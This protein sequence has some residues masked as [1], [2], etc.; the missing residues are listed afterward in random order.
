[1]V[2]QATAEIH[3][4]NSASAVEIVGPKADVDEDKA[5]AGVACGE[6]PGTGCG[7]NKLE[8]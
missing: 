7:S 3:G 8:W 2:K 6:E 5:A 1:M 4:R